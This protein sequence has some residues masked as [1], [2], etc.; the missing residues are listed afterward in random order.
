MLAFSP[1]LSAVP[2][3]LQAGAPAGY[4]VHLSVPQPASSEPTILGTADIKNVVATLP[5]GTVLSPSGA[6][7][8]TSCTSAQFGLGSAVA[9]SC[10]TNSKIGVVQVQAPALE[11]TLGGSVYLGAPECEQCSSQ[12]AAEGR[13]VHLFVQVE[14]N[15][16]DEQP[17]I[18]KLEGHGSINQQTGQ[19]TAT[20]TSLPQ[21]P[22]SDFKMTLNGGERAGLANPRSCGTV[23]T[24]M[25]LTPWSTPYTPDATLSYPFQ[26]DTGLGGSP[27]DCGV[28]PRFAP[29]FTAGTTVNQAGGFSP[30]TL[31]FVRADTDEYVNGLQLQMP[32]GL[33]GMIS[34]VSLCP[35]PQASLGTCSSAS[36]IGEASA[37]VGPGGDPYTVKGGKVFI[38][39]PYRGAPYGLSV[40][41]PATAGPFTLAGTTGNGTV[42]VRS[43]ITI[44]PQTTAITV[45]SDPFPTELD[46]IPLQIRQVNVTIGGA[47]G[48]FTF[49]PT[50]C[51]KTEVKGTLTSVAHTT[52]NVSSSFQ[53]TNCAVL[54]FKPKITV[55][56]A[57]KASKADGSSL[58][59]KIAY[60]KGVMGTEAWFKSAKLEIP[61]QL[62]ARLTTLQQACL[63]ATFE[64]NPAACPAR[65]LVGYAR[66][67]TPVLSAALTGP[68]YLVSYGATKLPDVIVVLQGEGVTAELSGETHINH[69]TGVT[70]ETFPDIPDVPF[71]TFEATLPTGPYSEF[72]VNLP[73]SSY[74]FCGRKLTMPV[75][76]EAA[77]SFQLHET[78]QLHIL[79]CTVA[80]KGRAAKKA[81]VAKKK[82]PDLGTSDDTHIASDHNGHGRIS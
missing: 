62:P 18:V 6:N 35:E 4:T 23:S 28:A 34:S 25:D 54:K 56:V 43:A 45:T 24:S 60:P 57:G 78:A 73:H 15:P 61:K 7:G 63:V 65:S 8:L 44:N 41:L 39:G 74:S 67:H 66:V 53:V 47:T 27:S 52:A 70:S 42:V 13:L 75:Q 38:T 68:I 11:E 48:N 69:K 49:N 10:P 40:V 31:S 36:Q 22:L 64:A 26:I 21:V 55:S 46:G 5:V 17:I 16:E 29:S 12:D 76:F 71:E 72:G 51:Q 37:T 20:F 77:N 9:A 30:F 32:P 80:K 59:F 58:D 50:S 2:D 14:G 79:K 33:L 3:T 82:S 19:L 81:R 1:S